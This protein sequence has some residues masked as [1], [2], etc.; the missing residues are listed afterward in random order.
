[1][2]LKSSQV[3]LPVQSSQVIQNFLQVIQDWPPLL[4]FK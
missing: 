2:S 1:L 4:S 3:V